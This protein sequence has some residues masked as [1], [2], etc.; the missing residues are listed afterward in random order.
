MTKKTSF[1]SI[2]LI[3]LAVWLVVRNGIS[4]TCRIIKNNSRL[5]VY[6]DGYLVGQATE[7]FSEKKKLIISFFHQD[8]ESPYFN[9]ESSVNFNSLDLPSGNYQ[10][11]FQI[12][13]PFSVKLIFSGE[14]TY[15]FYFNPYRHLNSGWEDPNNIITNLRNEQ[16]KISFLKGVCWM[17]WLL[18]KPF[19]FIIV[20]CF[21]ILIFWQ[22]FN[23]TKIKIQNKEKNFIS[24]SHIGIIVLIGF[25]FFWS[26]YLMT[27]YLGEVPHVPDS[28]SYMI[29]G[30]ILSS[31]HSTIPFSSIPKFIP[32][33]QYEQYFHHW[34]LPFNK[35]LIVFYPL[36][37][38]IVLAI[39]QII[40]HM[41]FIP[42]AI[43]GFIL[44]IIYFIVYKTTGSVFFSLFSS[45]LML[46]SPFFQTQTIDYMSHNTAAFYL[47]MAVIPIFFSRPENYFLTGFFGGMLFNTRPLTCAAFILILC[48]YEIAILIKVWT[49]NRK[50]ILKKIF[51]SLFGL[52]IPLVIFLSYNYKITGSILKTP[53][54]YHGILNKVGFG[55]DFKIGYGL[56][57]GFSNLA[58][59]SL[60]FLK[61]YFVSF[62]PFLLSIIL[63]PFFNRKSEVIFCLMM[64]LGLIFVWTLYDGNFFMYGPR[65]IYESTPF[66]ILVCGFAFHK[67]FTLFSPLLWKILTSFI[68]LF[69]LSQ[70]ALFELSWLGLRPAEYQ[71]I[72]HVPSN[73]N[74]LRNFNWSDDRLLKLKKK[75]QGLPQVFL[76]K[77]C[78]NWWC[79]S[80]HALN[81]YPLSSSKP[82]FLTLPDNYQGEIK[83]AKIIDYENFQ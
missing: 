10:K 83:S 9:E 17:I 55:Q 22:K 67:L 2:F 12:R 45:I 3:L 40:G 81:T 18:F 64:A 26:R 47:L 23:P 70:V 39:G 35:N 57:H 61:N 44:L 80:G 14:K 62:F 42:P 25:S 54:E 58:V 4:P 51:F 66:F 20:I 33:D 34:F 1:F 68:I 28:I 7:T 56:L 16:V 53:Y 6:F 43:G 69:Y 37:H 36:G 48:F 77:K 13:N 31:G 72:V 38:P 30:K 32:A 74:E 29:E 71:G 63:L 52:C 27:K 76:I 8:L 49:L 60:F 78:F 46:A 59:F 19:I 21:L 65:F 24:V 5:S 15:S 11:S 41:E 79:E 50:L 75:W 73:I 82:L